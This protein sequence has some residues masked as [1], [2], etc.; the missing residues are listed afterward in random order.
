MIVQVYRDGLEVATY[1]KAQ[2]MDDVRVYFDGFTRP[3]GKGAITCSVADG[4]RTLWFFVIRKGSRTV[5]LPHG[6]GA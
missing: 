6:G 3:P 2:S 4:A 5:L 1:H